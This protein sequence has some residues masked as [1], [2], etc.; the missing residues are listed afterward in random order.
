MTCRLAASQRLHAAV[1]SPSGA[2]LRV[3]VWTRRVRSQTLDALCRDGKRQGLLWCRQR[4]RGRVR[5]PFALKLRHFAGR[6]GDMMLNGYDWQPGSTIYSG[7]NEPNLRIVD[8]LDSEGLAKVAILA[9]DTTAAP[10]D[11][12]TNS[13]G[14]ISA[15]RLEG[16]LRSLNAP[17][18]RPSGEDFFDEPRRRICFR[19]WL[20]RRASARS[21]RRA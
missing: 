2:F 19:W 4:E 18:L 16:L 21:A 17:L 15:T 5:L 9:V 13:I 1:H 6:L 20:P 7:A 11:T 12:S 3:H 10:L 8:V 14:A